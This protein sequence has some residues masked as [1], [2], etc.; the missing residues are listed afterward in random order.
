MADGCSG[1]PD[2]DESSRGTDSDKTPGNHD[3]DRHPD[4]T[5]M[6]GRR[7]MRVSTMLVSPRWC[8]PNSDRLISGT[9]PSPPLPPTVFLL[10]GR[11]R[12]GRIAGQPGRAG[13]GRNQEHNAT[14]KMRP[15]RQ[16][17]PHP[18]G[19]C[20]RD[21]MHGRRSW[22]GW[23]EL[24]CKPGLAGANSCATPVRMFDSASPRGAAKRKLVACGLR[25]PLGCQCVIFTVA[26]SKSCIDFSALSS[27]RG[28]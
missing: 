24:V 6:S 4:C 14:E 5:R 1:R 21:V 12:A 8:A 28:S 2:S 13:S 26:K 19:S 9:F 23:A 22:P 10:V 18:A 7:S 15:A 11:I 20:A 25:A 17:S 27:R 16:V 3:Q